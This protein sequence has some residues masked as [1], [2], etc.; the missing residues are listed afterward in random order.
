MKILVSGSGGFLGGAFVDFCKSKGYAVLEIK[1]NNGG[2]NQNEATKVFY[3]KSLLEPDL[4]HKINCFKPDFF[5]HFAWKGVS[6]FSRNEDQYRYNINMTLESIEL[7][8][9]LGCAKWIGFGSQAEYGIKN[10]VISEEDLCNP[11]TNYGKSKLSLSISSLG[12]CESLG[13]EGAWIRVFSVFGENDHETALIP[14]VIQKM[15]K[16]EDVHLSDCS[17]TWD[18]LYIKDA[19]NALNCFMLQFNKGIYNLG[20]GKAII[21]KDVI[22][23]I[24]ELTNTSA[25]IM[26][27][28]IPYNDNSIRFLVAN[29][30]KLCCQTNWQPQFS[31]EVGI[32]NTVMYYKSKI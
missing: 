16:N 2:E 24:K 10:S 4:I 3:E 13:L 20:S 6:N 8:H 22:E 7:A 26:Y 5:F 31:L 30:N 9:Q 25:K 1:R 11:V 28:S 19:L 32:K 29:S 12:L 15:L 18:Y 23:L 17:Q 14:T 21:L 27:G